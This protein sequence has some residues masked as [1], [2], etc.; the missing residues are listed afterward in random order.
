MSQ[1]HPGRNTD[2]SK[3]LLLRAS[4]ETIA[5]Y[6]KAAKLRGHTRNSFFTFLAQALDENL[7]MI[8]D[9]ITWAAWKE[10][11]KDQVSRTARVVARKEA[12]LVLVEQGFTTSPYSE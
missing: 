3:Q 6:D 2:N 11:E 5:K 4:P 8:M 12:T 9:P 7:L 10:E 1:E